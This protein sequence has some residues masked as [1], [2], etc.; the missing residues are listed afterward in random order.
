MKIRIAFFI[1]GYPLTLTGV[2]QYS[3]IMRPS[4]C[5]GAYPGMVSFI[6][7]APLFTEPSVAAPVASMEADNRAAVVDHRLRNAEESDARKQGLCRGNTTV[8]IL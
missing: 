2:P 1:S 6:L 8:Q 3:G 7:H 4:L 5:G